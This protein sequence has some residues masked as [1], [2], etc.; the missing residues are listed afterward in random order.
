M[1]SALGQVSEPG[2]PGFGTEALKGL[3]KDQTEEQIIQLA[4]DD[5][6]VTGRIIDLEG[7]PV[8]GAMIRVHTL[9]IPQS[10]KDIDRWLEAAKRPAGSGGESRADDR[11][12][13]SILRADRPLALEMRPWIRII[14]LFP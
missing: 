7:R 5:V 9:G 14:G 8:A 10:S 13:R 2:S 11:C 6:P 4:R 3:P 12:T 1:A